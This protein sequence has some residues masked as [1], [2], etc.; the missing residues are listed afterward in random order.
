MRWCRWYS[1]QNEGCWTVGLVTMLELLH[2]SLALAACI[3]LWHICDFWHIVTMA[4]KCLG[5]VELYWVGQVWHI[6]P[7]LSVLE[8]VQVLEKSDPI[9]SI[10]EM[11]TPLLCFWLALYWMI[12]LV[13]TPFPRMPSHPV[14][15]LFMQMEDT[16]RMERP[17][18]F[19]TLLH[20]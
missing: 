19:S 11:H 5:T 13:Q 1:D 16:G 3:L 7:S 10:I 15:C 18:N 17:I 2:C 9:V 6:I 4:T 12:W 20:F 8:E 14:S